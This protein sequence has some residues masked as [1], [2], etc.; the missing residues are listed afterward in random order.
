M[1][2]PQGAPHG[3]TM[4]PGLEKSRT[5]TS[6]KGKTYRLTVTNERGDFEHDKKAPPSLTGRPETDDGEVFMGSARKVAKTSISDAEVTTFASLDDLLATLPLD[7]KMRKKPLK[8]SPRVEEEEKNVTVTAF[9]YATK[10]EDDNDFHVIM[11]SSASVDDAQ[12]MTAEVSGLP[13]DAPFKARLAKARTQFKDFFGDTQLPG[14]RYVKFDPPVPI[15]VTGSLFYDID[16]KPG[17]IGPLGNRPATSWEVHPV[18][19]IVFEP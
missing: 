18:T 17:D 7:S 12:F 13:T 16:H 14:S 3:L 15:K 6:A 11:G 9:L 8:N 2:H 10:K 19:D 1:A 4:Q 5:L